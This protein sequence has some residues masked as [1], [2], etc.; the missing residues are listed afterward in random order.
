MKK[1]KLSLANIILAE[2]CYK[3]KC[4]NVSKVLNAKKFLKTGQSR[5]NP[6]QRSK[7]MGYSGCSLR[8]PSMKGV[9]RPGPSKK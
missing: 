6:H 1:M 3:R 8:T 2:E 5:P 9:L 4:K 7:G